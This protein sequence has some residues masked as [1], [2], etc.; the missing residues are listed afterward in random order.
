[1]TIAQ[2]AAADTTR[3]PSLDATHELVIDTAR[4][5]LDCEGFVTRLFFVRL[6]ED[7]TADQLKEPGIWR[8]VQASRKSSFRQFDTVTLVAYDE[9]W[10]AEA[11]VVR[12][13]A[14]SAQLSKP[15]ITSIPPRYNR[16][17]EDALYRVKWFGAGFAVERKI[18]GHRVTSM[19]ANAAIAERD[20]ARLYPAQVGA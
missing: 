2:T 7:F 1:M 16:L 6:P 17:F 9:T 3:S 20:L 10:L 18:D 5:T 13:D 12:A 19:A 8:K 15:R 14:V 4:V 11:T